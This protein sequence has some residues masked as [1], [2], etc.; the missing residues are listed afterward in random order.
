MK[1]P[2][3]LRIKQLVKNPKEFYF[4]PLDEDLIVEEIQNLNLEKVVPQDDIPVK[5]LKLNEG[6]ILQHLC[7]IYDENKENVN[8][9]K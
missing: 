2:I 1:N 7:K 8:F 9:P 4:V 5:I 3:I 6:V